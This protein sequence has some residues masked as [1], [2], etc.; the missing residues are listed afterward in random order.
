MRPRARAVPRRV[1]S[2]TTG[3]P[4]AVAVI[5]MSMGRASRCDRSS[6][7]KRETRDLGAC[8][9]YR[10]RRRGARC[11]ATRVGLG[12]LLFGHSRQAKAPKGE[13]AE[14]LHSERTKKGRGFQP[15]ENS[16]IEGLSLRRGR[17][18]GHLAS[19]ITLCLTD[20]DTLEPYNLSSPRAQYV[21]SFKYDNNCSTSAQPIADSSI[22]R[23]RTYVWSKIVRKSLHMGHIQDVLSTCVEHGVE[24]ARC[25]SA[26]LAILTAGNARSH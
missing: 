6:P 5:S 20:L 11:R 2:R 10:G 1:P 3:A 22:Y 4:T 9:A 24:C 16:Q 23:S 18:S 21:T 19:H 17:G 25:V 12:L 15:H 14:L 26:E 7:H 8:T 13:L